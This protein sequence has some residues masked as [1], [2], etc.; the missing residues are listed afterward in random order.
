MVRPSTRREAGASAVIVALMLA[1]LGGFLA[2]VLNAGHYMMVKS[3]LQNA[4]DAAALAAARE[5]DGMPQGLVAARAKA[6]D[7]AQRHDTD[8]D[9]PVAIEPASDVLFGTWDPRLPRESAFVP[10]SETAPNAPAL[11][12]AVYVRAG[13]ETARGNPLEVFFPVFSA[14]KTEASVRAAAIAVKGAPCDECAVP[15]VFADCLIIRA[16]GTLDC[17]MQLVFRSDTTDNVGFTNLLDGVRTV[18]TSGIIDTL[19][20]RCAPVG[21]GD[22]I[23]VANGNNLNPNVVRA[24]ESYVAAHGPR[25]T[26]PIVSP[27]DGCPAK[28][29]GLLPVVGFATF[30]IVAI[31]GPPDQSITLQLDCGQTVVSRSAGCGNFGTISDRP[32]LVR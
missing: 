23:G 29:T 19:S 18:S 14:G 8:R 5:L 6:V 11:I 17:G 2:L 24:F 13:R 7:F 12:D 3:E 16:D 4:C 28:F 15:L 21:A 27:P 10:L 30:T 31:T 26:V 22:D 9:R 20:A 32:V 25:V 1:V